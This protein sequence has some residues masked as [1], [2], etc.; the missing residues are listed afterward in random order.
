MGRPV[1]RLRGSSLHLGL[2]FAG[3]KGRWWCARWRFRGTELLNRFGTVVFGVEINATGRSSL[4]K[5][6][7]FKVE[8]G[9]NRFSESPK[10]S[11]TLVECVDEDGEGL[12]YRATVVL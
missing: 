12:G 4:E 3:L 6:V 5:R 11:M 7:P 9:G 10:S 8:V 2:S 1:L